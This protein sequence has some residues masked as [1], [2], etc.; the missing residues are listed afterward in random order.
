ML[1]KINQAGWKATIKPHPLQAAVEGGF[2]LDDF[3]YND[4]AGTVTCPNQVTRRLSKTRV[5]TFGKVCAGCP[6]R[7]RCTTS[8]RGRLVKLSEFERVRRDHRERAK[9][10]DF[11]QVYRAKRPLVERSIAWLTR[12]NRRLRYL[13]V[14]KNN[15]WLH[16]RVA[17]LNLRRLLVLGLHFDQ[18]TWQIG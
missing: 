14:I 7:D 8:A 3:A 16:H 12:G 9:Q 15:A 18:G 2:T 13:G 6:L 17:A 5:A 11:R 1:D 4:E 10:P